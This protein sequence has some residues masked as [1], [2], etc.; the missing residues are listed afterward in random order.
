M[1]QLCWAYFP[2]SDERLHRQDNFSQFIDLRD[3]VEKYSGNFVLLWHNNN[4]N[5]DEWKG[6]KDIY[7]ELISSL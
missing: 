1:G 2:D 4:F 3:T 7:Q 5:I 6:Y